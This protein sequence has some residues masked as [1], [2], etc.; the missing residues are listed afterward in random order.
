VG[1]NLKQAPKNGAK[2][3]TYRRAKRLGVGAQV[4]SESNV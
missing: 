4:E 1:L 3:G 2:L